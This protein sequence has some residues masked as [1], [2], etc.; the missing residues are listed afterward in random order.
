MAETQQ[1]P[2]GGFLPP[3]P[4]SL[5]SPV[6]DLPGAASPPDFLTDLPH[7]RSRPL[8]PNSNKEDMVR[9]YASAKLMEVAR[10]YVKKFGD[11][12]P[13]DDVVGYVR[14]ADLCADLDSII[15]VL[16]RSGTRKSHPLLPSPSSYSLPPVL[17]LSR[18]QRSSKS[19]SSCA[20][21]ANSPSTPRPSRPNPS[22]PSSSSASSTTA[23]RAWRL[24]GIS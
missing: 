12:Q 9:N 5:N 24:A 15:N 7:P 11:S 1:S 20:S 3:T 13:G 6:P 2:Q 19:R 14:F 16:W 8:R 18:T 10:R 23:S 21:P 22:P 17:T 4:T